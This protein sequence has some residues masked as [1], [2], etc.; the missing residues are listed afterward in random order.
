MTYGQF[1]GLNLTLVAHMKLR[2]KLGSSRL[3]R[4][5]F[6]MFKISKNHKL[7]ELFLWKKKEDEENR[8]FQLRFL[9]LVKG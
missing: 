8:T 1:L 6:G 4:Q 9:N 2:T 5:S 3:A 7:F